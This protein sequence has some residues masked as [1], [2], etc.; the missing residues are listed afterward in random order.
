MTS[1]ASM[2]YLVGIAVA[3]KLGSRGTSR[4]NGPATQASPS[5][6]GVFSRPQETKSGP[7]ATSSWWRRGGGGRCH[8]HDRRGGSTLVDRGEARDG[9]AARQSAAAR[10]RGDA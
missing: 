3:N 7:A 8:G 9:G 10:M 4:A 6:C 1:P 5:Y 2:A